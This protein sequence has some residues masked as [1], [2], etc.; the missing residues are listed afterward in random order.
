MVD[1]THITI[2]QADLQRLDAEDKW[3]EVEDGEILT[4]DDHVPLLH[5]I[6]VQNLY[7]LLR[8]AVETRRLGNLFM[9]G[10]RYILAGTPQAIQRA[11]KPD[12][13]FL[14]A[15]RIPVDFD[16]SGDFVGAPDLAVE[17]MS[18]GQ[19]SGFLLSK[20]ERYLQAGSEEAWLIYPKQ[21]SIYQYRSSEDEPTI[22]RTER[23]D[24]IDTAAL[25]PGLKLVAA[26]LF[27]TQSA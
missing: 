19:G 20:I 7:N 8:P 21:K 23:S 17:V 27:V 18:P 1:K 10:A 25:F 22:Y 14:R 2:T 3:I 24:I 16:W 11:Y 12:F 15:G 13:S 4:I 9:R 26:D 6:I 5:I